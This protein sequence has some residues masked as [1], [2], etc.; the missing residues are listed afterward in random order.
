MMDKDKLVQRNLEQ[1]IIHTSFTGSL[2]SGWGMGIVRLRLAEAL[3]DQTADASSCS[4]S[5]FK[6]IYVSFKDLRMLVQICVIL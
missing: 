2:N 1:T 5:L 4:L 3:K 6:L